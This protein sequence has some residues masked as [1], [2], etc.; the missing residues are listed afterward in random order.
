MKLNIFR[1]KKVKVVD[2]NNKT[3]I[4]KVELY[5]QPNDNDGQEAISL[6]SGIWFDESDIKSIEEIQDL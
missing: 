2:V 4:G 3:Y 5:T 1:N 6:S